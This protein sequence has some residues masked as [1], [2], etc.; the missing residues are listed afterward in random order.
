MFFESS[1]NKID[2]E[3]IENFNL[4]NTNELNPDIEKENS[5]IWQIEIPAIGLIAPIADGTSAKIMNKYVGHFI[6]T[7]KKEGNIGLAAHNRGYNV[8]YFAKLKLLK[9]NDLI[10]YTYKNNIFKYSVK[11]IGVI[12]DVDWSKLEQ[13]KEEKITLITCL[14]NE[15]EYRRY[16]QAI[17][18]N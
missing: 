12:K 10:I 16:I 4:A 18:I 1:L 8:N 15:P 6:E 13:S 7:P 11:E 2:P 5:N 14:E 17:K 9:E 3:N